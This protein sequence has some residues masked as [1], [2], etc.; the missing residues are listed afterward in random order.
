MRVLILLSVLVLL[1][2]LNYA[3]NDDIDA[4]KAQIDA[5]KTRIDH[6]ERSWVLDCC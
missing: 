1:A 2:Q 3:D 5:L 6:L 4:L